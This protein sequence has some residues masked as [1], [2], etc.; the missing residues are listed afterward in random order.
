MD[1][2]FHKEDLKKLGFTLC[3]AKLEIG[4][5]DGGQEPTHKKT[6]QNNQGSSAKEAKK[7]WKGKER[8]VRK[9]DR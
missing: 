1:A 4:K 6:E 8:L 7:P 9:R 2:K 3:L 5:E